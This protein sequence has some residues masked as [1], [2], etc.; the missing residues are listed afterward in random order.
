MS[1]V[2]YWTD[3]KINI[4]IEIYLENSYCASSAIFVCDFIL[5]LNHDRHLLE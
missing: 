4:V 1:L 5:K 2:F 3:Y